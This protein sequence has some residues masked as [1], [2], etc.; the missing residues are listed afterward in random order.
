MPVLD[1]S[2]PAVW[3]VSGAVLVVESQ[4]LVGAYGVGIADILFFM[5]F[6]LM[7]VGPIFQGFLYEVYA[8]RHDALLVSIEP[9]MN[10]KRTIFI[11]EMERSI[12]I[13]NPDNPDVPRFRTPIRLARP[14]F[15]HPQLGT[16]KYLHIEHNLGI[17]NRLRFRD[18]R[19]SFSGMSVRLRG[20]D[21]NVVLSQHPTFESDDFG[22]RPV[23]DL[24][25]AGWDWSIENGDLMPEE[26]TTVA[27]EME[28]IP[29]IKKEEV[30]EM[31]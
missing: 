7:V 15:K 3:S 16:Q 14:Y 18:G 26:L 20:V 29:T 19:G 1:E 9:W 2:I 24:K 12:R 22:T 11:S 28:R 27:P 8:N 23:F 10:G 6:V 17:G 5:G 4:S 31:P 30:E 21:G 13:A 25:R